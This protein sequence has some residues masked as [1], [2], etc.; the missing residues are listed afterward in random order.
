MAE[1]KAGSK[2]VTLRQTYR[3]YLVALAGNLATLSLGCALAWP[4]PTLPQLRADPSPRLNLTAAQASWVGSLTQ[5]A[6]AAGP[7]PA[8]LAVA[9]LGC[10]PTFLLVGAVFALG[11]AL[12]GAAR[13]ASTLLVARFLMG[14]GFGAVLV[15]VPAYC[16][17]IAQDEIRGRLGSFLRMQLS[18]GYLFAYSVGPYVSYLA[19]VLASACFP[20]ALLVAAVF[21]PESPYRLVAFGRLDEAR[22]VL[23]WLR[24]CDDY[25]AR[26]QLQLVQEFVEKAGREEGTFHDLFHQRASLKAMLLML[27]LFL[28][29]QLSGIAAITVYNETIFR[30]SGGSVD[31]SVAAIIVGVVMF[32]ASGS[33]SLLVDRL[34]RRPLL[35]ASSAGMALSMALLGTY[36]YWKAIGSDT[37]SVGWLPVT[38]L[39]THIIAFNIGFGTVPFAQ[40]GEMFSPGAKNK[41]STIVAMW[42][43]LCSALVARFFLDLAAALGTHGVFWLFGATALVAGVFTFF[44]LPETKEIPQHVIHQMLGRRPASRRSEDGGSELH[45]LPSRV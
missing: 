1:Q 44:L 30:E 25:E 32:L 43:A 31:A 19:L 21:L 10:R 38:S 8:A 45:K 28:F 23:C 39:V 9:R 2:R 42:T 18:L 3:Q 13:A 20:A 5:F 35:M 26:R 15:L 7:L 29:Q 34:G 4:S 27:A 16:G 6:G 36:F 14:A 41:A 37:S 17:E 40:M 22:E 33:C 12:T 11:W 24:R